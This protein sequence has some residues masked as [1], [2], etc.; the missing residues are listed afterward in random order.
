MSQIPSSG[1]YPGKEWQEVPRDT[2]PVLSTLEISSSQFPPFIPS[3]CPQVMHHPA[4]MNKGVSMSWTCPQTPAPSA[5]FQRAVSFS[6]SGIR[7]KRHL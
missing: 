3:S 2:I 6:F 7:E 5:P 1:N 4:S